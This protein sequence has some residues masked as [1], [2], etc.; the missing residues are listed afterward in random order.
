VSLL[1]RDVLLGGKKTNIHV[2]GSRIA[3]IGVKAKA[4]HVI[5]G[6][7]KAAMPGFVN[8]HTHAAMTL[9]R[10]YADDMA[11][12]VWLER[13][14][15][16]L[17]AKMTRDDVYWGTKLACL[18]MIR[19]G[20][21]CFND[22]YWH[23]E[24]AVKATEESG[25]RGVLSSVFIDMFGQDNSTKQR[26]EAES[27]MREIKAGS[28]VRL[29]LGPHAI[30]TVTEESLKWVKEYADRHNALIHFHLSETRKEVDDCIKAHGMRPVE[31]LNDIGFLGPNLVCAH[32]VWVD[33]KEI[34]LLAKSGV[35]VA[36]CPTSNM[37]LSVG[38]A[39]R[40]AALKKAGVTVSLGTD[41]CA[42]NNSLDMFGAMKTAAILSKF[43]SND[44]TLMPASDAYNMGT[45]EG[46]RTLGLDVGRIQEGALADIVLIDLRRPQMTPLHNLTSNLVYSATG[47]CVDTV[48]CDGKVLM[49]DGKV[50]GE[51]RILEAAS[52]RAAG[53]EA[54]K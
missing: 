34:A 29:A 43:D 31:Y 41:G 36:H 51:E 13:K 1:I 28:R 22:M 35:K 33:D 30:Y 37:K 4:E 44:P 27:Q 24:G 25:I 17:E 3:C 47:G 45:L 10:G 42:S 49:M 26:R 53:L 50:D 11:L 12:Q 6:S 9:L 14:I 18:E 16:P 52:E 7:G 8:T 19:S 21:T 5:D 40:Y 2:E 23:L 38:G 15:W 39:M 32:C 20:T 46:A 48:V 54:G